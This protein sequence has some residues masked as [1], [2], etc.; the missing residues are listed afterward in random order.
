MPVCRST[1]ILLA[2]LC[3]APSFAQATSATPSTE[4]HDV[5]SIL[6]QALAVHPAARAAQQKLVEAQAKLAEAAAQRRMQPVFSGSVSGSHGQVAQPASTQ[7]FGTVEATIAAP[8]PNGGRL[9]A[10]SA[11]AAGGV[12]AAQ[13]GLD[14]ARLDLAFRAED[15][16][17]RV[18]RARGERDIA[19]DNLAQ[20]ERQ[21]DDTKKRVDAGD[22]P[23]AD[24]LKTQVQLAEARVSLVR[25]RN[26][27]RVAEQALDSL[28]ALDLS[29]T[30]SLAPA[31][32]LPPLTE[33]RDQVVSQALARSPD[34]REAQ[35]NLAS[36]E[37]AL[38][39]ALHSRDPEWTVQATHTRT[40]DVTAYSSLTSILL[41]VNI[42][43]GSGGV[44]RQ[45][46]KQAQAQLEQA[47]AALALARQQ[48]Q[49]DAE[50]AYLDVGAAEANRSG[51]QETLRIAQDSLAKARQS[52]DAGLTTTRDV[53]DA[54]LAVT[55]ARTEAN[56]AVYDLAVARA[57]LDQSIGKEPLP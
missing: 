30:V 40:S 26:A 12:R 36:A 7:T 1:L 47:R 25:A 27:A 41:S 22:L 4:I 38:R 9:S 23:P 44:A 2:L 50:Q 14:R 34:V 53:L 52:Y 51:T 46:S 31:P 10:L 13:A 42:P 54:Q 15:A 19:A 20:A 33:T 11:Q 29:T 35:A 48:A 16:Y 32:T 21:V 18:L 17:Y 45:Q 8:L 56:A 3:S 37:A 28:I 57:K 49:L 39:F 43:L 5:H 6:A 55:Q 24:V